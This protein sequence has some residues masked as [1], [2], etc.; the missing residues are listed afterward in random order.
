VEWNLIQFTM[1]V[2]MPPAVRRN[3]PFTMTHFTPEET[4]TSFSFAIRQP[5]PAQ[6][7]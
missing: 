7:R 2:S 5:F 1:I 6:R 3:A 4:A